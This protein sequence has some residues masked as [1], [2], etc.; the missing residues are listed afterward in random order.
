MKQNQE[1]DIRIIRQMMERSSKFL[2]LSGLAGII[3]GI[4]AI[5]G[6]LYAYFYIFN[7][8]TEVHLSEEGIIELL[9]DAFIVLVIAMGACL[10][11]SWRKA[12]KSGQKLL[13][14]VTYRT[15][16]NLAIPLAAGGVFCLVYLL[17]GDFVTI[18][19]GTLLFYGLALVNV[20]KFTYEEI[21][22][23]GL[24][25]IVFGLLAAWLGCYALWFWIL[26][27]GVCHIVYG[28]M[29]YIKYDRK[30]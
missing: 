14:K 24:T 12:K 16:Y 7:G 2:S 23:L 27:F 4:A 18:M 21:H 1:E 13:N 15:L 8:N 11:F 10:Y 3:A 19:A 25:E 20:S 5:A 30:H 28:V 26:G 9:V 17:R 6:A 22:Y 29:I